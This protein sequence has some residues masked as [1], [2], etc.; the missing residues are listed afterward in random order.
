M[1]IRE[2]IIEDFDEI[3]QLFAN[4]FSDS[5]GQS[6][7]LVIGDLSYGLMTTSKDSDF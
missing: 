6:E 1:Q 3:K 5:E 7:G 4:T 2:A